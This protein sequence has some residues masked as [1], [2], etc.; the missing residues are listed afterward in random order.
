MA[1]ELASRVRAGNVLTT[2]RTSGVKLDVL[3]REEREHTA[4]AR[5]LGYRQGDEGLLDEDWLR[6]AR[7]SRRVMDRLFWE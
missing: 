1:W 2:G 7:K 3:P 6:A 5:M 4:L